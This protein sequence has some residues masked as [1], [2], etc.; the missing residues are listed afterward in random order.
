MRSVTRVLLLFCGTIMA[1]GS[2]RSVH[3]QAVSL[4]CRGPFEM[5]RQGAWS[6]T[7]RPGRREAGPHGEN[8][9]PG[10]CAFPD[11]GM[12]A[13][14][15]RTVVLRGGAERALPRG[16]DLTLEMTVQ[17]LKL[18]IWEMENTAEYVSFLSRGDYV[19][20][21]EVY[22]SESGPWLTGWTQENPL[23][24]VIPH[25]DPVQPVLDRPRP[26]AP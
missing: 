17:R 26:P 22:R 8:L 4:H 25:S 20:I 3:A 16:E 14:E 9:P 2:A 7:F 10:T 24:H 6:F 15:P 13:G 18:I 21:L 23:R 12:R 5:V 1:L 11:R 19:T